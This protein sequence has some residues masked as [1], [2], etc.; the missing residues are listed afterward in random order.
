MNNDSL[1]YSRS[2]VNQKLESKNK[3]A[4]VE[5]KIDSNITESVVFDN[6]YT[7]QPN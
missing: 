7:P 6:P 1:N 2:F 5:M 3:N 4:K